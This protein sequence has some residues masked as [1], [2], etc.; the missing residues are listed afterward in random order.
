M[1]TTVPDKIAR[2]H[3]EQACCNGE[4]S[5]A[6]KLSGLN[7]DNDVAAKANVFVVQPSEM[8]LLPRTLSTPASDKMSSSGLDNAEL[9]SPERS[10]AM[11]QNA[12]NTQ[13]GPKMGVEKY[14]Q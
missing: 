5:S 1:E 2:Q 12:W 11:R 10:K 3:E 13:A 8:R 7:S 4:I 6:V 9:P 14:T